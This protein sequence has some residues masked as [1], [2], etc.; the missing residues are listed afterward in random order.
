MIGWSCWSKVHA[1]LYCSVPIRSQQFISFTF[2]KVYYFIG[3]FED[4]IS[5]WITTIFSNASFK[6]LIFI[7]IYISLCKLSIVKLIFELS[8]GRDCRS[9][10]NLS[11]WVALFIDIFLLYD[12]WLILVDN[13]NREYVLMLEWIYRMSEA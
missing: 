4:V 5:Y 13:L 9:I 8:K 2:N 1:S 6:Q 10:D 12:I 7:N 3:C 11:C